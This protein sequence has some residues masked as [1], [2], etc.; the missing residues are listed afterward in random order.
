MNYF[1][2][3]LAFLGKVWY[4]R[5]IWIRCIRSLQ[6]Y[7][8]PRPNSFS[9]LWRIIEEHRVLPFEFCSSYRRICLHFTFQT[10][11]N[12][13]S[14]VFRLSEVSLSSDFVWGTVPGDNDAA[15]KLSF[16]TSL[17]EQQSSNPPYLGSSARDFSSIL[18]VYGPIMCSESKYFRP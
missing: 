13:R 1:I 8:L 11:F 4:V 14:V 9:R 2:K 16:S 15:D 5:I 18:S 17:E 7:A 10:L 6:I 3:C 12:S